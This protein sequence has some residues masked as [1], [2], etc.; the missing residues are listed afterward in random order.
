MLS[1]LTW[2]LEKANFIQ[3]TYK[4]IGH[5]SKYTCLNTAKIGKAG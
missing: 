5:I 3:M 2:D 1:A 4:M